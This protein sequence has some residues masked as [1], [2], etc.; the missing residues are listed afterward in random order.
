[1]EPGFDDLA[2]DAPL[3]KD[4]SGQPSPVNLDSLDVLD[5]AMSIG[6]EF[7]LSNDQFETLVSN[8]SDFSN[9]RTVNDI[10]KV[11]IMLINN[12]DGV[13]SPTRA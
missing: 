1:L 12:S 9:L 3:F 10:T 13:R 6:E 2:D 5:L 4:G 11:I 7:G 8:D